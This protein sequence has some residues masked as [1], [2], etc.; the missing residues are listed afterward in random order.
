MCQRKFRLDISK[1]SFSRREVR[2]W[3]RLPTEVIKFPSLEVFKNCMDVVLMGMVSGHGRNELMV[4]LDD[5]SV[6]F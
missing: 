5:L 6:V 1:K 4:G 3:N 2:H